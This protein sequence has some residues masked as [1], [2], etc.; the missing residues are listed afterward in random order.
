MTYRDTHAARQ[1]LRA[2]ATRQGGYVTTRQAAEAGYGGSHLTYHVS[3]G[4]LTRVAHGLYRLTDIPPDE[5]DDLIRLALWSRDRAGTP[6][7]VVSHDTALLLHELSDVLPNRIHL[8]VPPR[9]RK[10]APDGCVFHVGRVE[11]R[12]RQPWTVF[13]VTAPARTLVDVAASTSVTQEQLDLAVHQALAR[14]LMTAS[15]LA[16]RVADD[17]TGRLERAA[18]AASSTT[19]PR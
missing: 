8:T 17:S 11:R 18:A 10:P 1:A 5:H 6:Q 7:I 15:E 4:L 12:D 16:R 3:A 14:G 13:S 19:S 2:I 9:F